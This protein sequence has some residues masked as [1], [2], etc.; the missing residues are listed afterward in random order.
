MK[1]Q[2]VVILSLFIFSFSSYSTENLVNIEAMTL[3]QKQSYQMERFFSG[4]VIKQ[5]DAKLA[6]P[7]FSE[8]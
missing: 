2:L 5:Q 4:R 1:S 6:F 8:M 7:L 3:E